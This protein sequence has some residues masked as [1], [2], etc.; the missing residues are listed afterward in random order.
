MEDKVDPLQ[1]GQQLPYAGLTGKAGNLNIFA[2]RQP[3]L[4]ILTNETV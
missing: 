3:T 4:E 2:F 1:K